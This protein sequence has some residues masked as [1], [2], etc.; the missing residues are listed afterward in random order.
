MKKAVEVH[1]PEPPNFIMIGEDRKAM[2][3][4]KFTDD[5]LKEI[6]KEWTDKLLKKAKERR[7]R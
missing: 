3:I 6:A 4:A 5:E 7:G 1:I 2:S